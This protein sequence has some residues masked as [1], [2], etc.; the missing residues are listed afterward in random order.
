MYIEPF[1][2]WCILC[3]K[4]L[5]ITAASFLRKWASS[6]AYGVLSISETNTMKNNSVSIW[7]ISINFDKKLTGYS[8]FLRNQTQRTRN[9]LKTLNVFINGGFRLFAILPVIIVD[10]IKRS[11]LY[12]LL[13][14]FLGS[15]KG[16]L[17]SKTITF[18]VS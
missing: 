3:V 13:R 9:I 11:Y 4:H 15:F 6:W 18:I 14:W 12:K 5:L 10:D 17:R 2:Y 1:A 16:N 8:P 7:Y